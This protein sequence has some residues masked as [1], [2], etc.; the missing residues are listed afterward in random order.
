MRRIFRRA[1]ALSIAFAL[2]ASAAAWREC[3]AL[4]AATV[5][6][7]SSH[8]S[9]AAHHHASV[10]DGENAYHAMHHER[11]TGDP[12][13]PAADDHGCMKCCT[14]CAVANALLPDAN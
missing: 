14:M 9:H 10:D 8:A 7:A 2:V 6:V 3:T 12:A 11:R 1:L 4:Q 5:A 13:A